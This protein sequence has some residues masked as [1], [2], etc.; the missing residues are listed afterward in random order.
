MRLREICDAANHRCASRIGS[1]MFLHVEVVCD[2]TVP[3]NQ[4]GH[5]KFVKTKTFHSYER[6]ILLRLNDCIYA[7][8]RNQ[9]N[10][11]DSS[12]ILEVKTLSRYYV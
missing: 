12:L 9:H 11:L 1:S 6:S 5:Q 2:L 7:N 4:V 3:G 10:I 8:I